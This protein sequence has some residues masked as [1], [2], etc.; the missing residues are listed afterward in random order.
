VDDGSESSPQVIYSA[1]Y[2]FI[3]FVDDG[4]HPEFASSRR[5]P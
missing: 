2:P 5:K 1:L 4:S 3:V